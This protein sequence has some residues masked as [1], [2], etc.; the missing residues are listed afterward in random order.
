MRSP[1]LWFEVRGG[2]LSA[3]L[4]LLLFAWLCSLALHQK[5]T[6]F[7]LYIRDW[8]HAFSSP[9]L[10]ALFVLL[11]WLGS[12]FVLLSMGILLAVLFVNR[13]S[14]VR[15]VTITLYGAIILSAALKLLFHVSRP[16]PFFGLSVPDTHSFPSAHAFIS[17]CFFSLIAQFINQRVNQRLAR[18]CLWAIACLI[19]AAIGVSRVYL[20]MQYPTSVLAGYAA[21][22]VWMELVKIIVR[23]LSKSLDN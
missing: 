22:H 6:P 5:T 1:K 21:A 16:E 13:F 23:K 9:R 17:F 15:V 18:V 4:A 10:T 20:G 8:L 7:D 11:S 3:G 14:E 12:W 2:L 19:I